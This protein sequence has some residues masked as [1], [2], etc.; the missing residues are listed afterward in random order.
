MRGPIILAHMI[1]TEVHKLIDKYGGAVPRYTSFPTAVQFHEDYTHKDARTNLKA[2][3]ADQNIS[4]YIHIPFCH[5][6]CHYCGCHTKIVHRTKPI[7]DYIET[8]CREIRLAGECLENKLVIRRVH[9]GG[10][11]PNY[12]PIEGLRKIMATICDVF[13][14]DQNPVIDMEC[15]PRLLDR[16]KIEDLLGLGVKRFSFGIQDFNQKVQAAINRFQSFELVKEQVLFLRARDMQNINFDLIIGLPEQT[17]ETVQETLQQVFM[18]EPSRIAVFP[19]AHVPWMKKHQ[20]LLEKYRLPDAQRRFAMAMLMHEMLNASGYRE[21]GIDHYALPHDAL[22]KAQTKNSMKRNFQGY[23]DDDSDVVL[24]FGL[25]A[26]SQFKSSYAQ[27]TTD[28][29]SYRKNVES[30]ILPTRRGLVL[31]SADTILREIIMTIMCDFG[32]DLNHYEADF[33][34]YDRLAGLQ[35]DGLITIKDK[36]LKITE[37]G[38]PFTRVIAST[39]DPYLNAREQR[40]AKA[41]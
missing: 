25:S 18:L 32:I 34:P 3:R 30:G 35:Q 12:A 26:I 33:I 10:G 2:L 14:L 13:G 11:S 16:G 38:K 17:L 40:H 36:T 19:Y 37:A 15:D 5:S 8:L 6:L 41:I 9:F 39:F 7:S 27:N 20:K 22:A 24:G 4:I 29:P 1:I 28:V 31:S 23:T 21:I